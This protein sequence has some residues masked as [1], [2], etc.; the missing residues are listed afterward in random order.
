VTGETSVTVGGHWDHSQDLLI[1]Q[2]T[3]YQLS[4]GRSLS[5]LYVFMYVTF[6]CFIRQFPTLTNRLGKHFIFKDNDYRFILIRSFH[7]MFVKIRAAIYS[8]EIHW[9]YF[10]YC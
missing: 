10:V 9:C 3:V 6:T 4:Y 1:V 5:R 7:S 8:L 2:P